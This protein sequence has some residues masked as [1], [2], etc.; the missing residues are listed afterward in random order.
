MRLPRFVV[1]SLTC[2]VALVCLGMAAF[3]VMSG[4]TK[5]KGIDH[6]DAL[7]SR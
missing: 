7:S 3:T 2:G 1:M 6:V 5:W 4:V